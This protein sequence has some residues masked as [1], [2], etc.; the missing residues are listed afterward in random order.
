[1]LFGTS[2]IILTIHCLSEISTSCSKA[3]ACSNFSFRVT[4]LHQ[5]TSTTALPPFTALCTVVHSTIL[6]WGALLG[7]WS[8]LPAVFSTDGSDG[9]A[10]K[11]P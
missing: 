3:P 9:R 2:P 10:F 7:P 1:M 6:N 4:S 5:L 11:T 8:S